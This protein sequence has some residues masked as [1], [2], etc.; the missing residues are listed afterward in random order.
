MIESKTCFSANLLCVEVIYC[1]MHNEC[2]IRLQKPEGCKTCASAVVS[3][4]DY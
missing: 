2:Y 1:F 4:V 3:A